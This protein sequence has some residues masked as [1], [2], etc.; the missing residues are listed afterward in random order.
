MKI[1]IIG[2]NH[3]DEAKDDKAVSQSLFEAATQIGNELTKRTHTIFI[4]SESPNTVDPYIFNGA[5]ES[6]SKLSNIEIHRPDDGEIPFA[7]DFKS[8]DCAMGMRHH[9]SLNWDV[10]HMETMKE[11][12]AILII[13]GG[14]RSIRTCVAANMLGKTVIPVASFGG[15]A[16]A[17]WSY[18]SSKREQFYYGGLSDSEIDELTWPWR[19]DRSAGHIVNSLEK[20]HEAIEQANRVLARRSI[21]RSVL[22]S[23]LGLMLTGVIGWIYFLANGQNVAILNRVAIG[24]IFAVVCFAGFMGSAMKSLWELRNGRKL[25]LSDISGDVALGLGAGVISS[26][27]YLVVQLAVTGDISKALEPKDYMR[28]ALLVSLVAVFAAM[29]LD[30][31]FSRFES[32]RESVFSGDIGNRKQKD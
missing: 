26:I 31:A 10:V 18:A 21:P 2:S 17:V 22:S 12:D 24:P 13:G 6:S 14:N 9:A 30:T 3:Y 27:L 1:F 25:T 19:S 23:A 4:G 11:A 7:D 29:Y 8:P 28:I 5:K 32:V 15:G 16:K 20:V